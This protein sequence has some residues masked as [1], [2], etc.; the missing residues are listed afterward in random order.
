MNKIEVTLDAAKL[1]PLVTNRTYTNKGGEVVKVQEVKFELVPVKE[2]NQK[3]VYEKD[4]FKIVKTH[5]AAVKQTKEER[6][7]KVQTMYIGEG[8]SHIWGNAVETTQAE[9]VI[10]YQQ[11]VD[12]KN[13]DL[14][15]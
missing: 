9:E 4:D 14:P 12:Q 8:F 7:A 6:A 3:I 13:N 11:A 1:R 15:F 10:N 2:E 5:F